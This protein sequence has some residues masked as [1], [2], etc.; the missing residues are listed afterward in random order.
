[1][2]GHARESH[3]TPVKGAASFVF[4][5]FF[6][7]AVPA[8]ADL[9]HDLLVR[10][11]ASW[12]AHQES[13]A[14][15]LCRRILSLKNTDENRHP[16]ACAHYLLSV[17]YADRLNK[18]DL[19]IAELGKALEMSLAESKPEPL[20]DV[21]CP[22]N[23]YY[24]RGM[25]KLG[26]QRVDDAIVDFKKS[27]EYDP[28]RALAYRALGLAYTTRGDWKR[29]L[30]NYSIAL[31]LLPRT[32]EFY[33]PCLVLRAE[34]YQKTGQLDR[35]VVDYTKLITMHGESTDGYTLRAACYAKLHKFDL[36]LKDYSTLIRLDPHDDN[37]Y[38]GRGDIFME[39]GKA[40]SAVNEYTR[41]IKLDPSPANYTARARAYEKLGRHDLAAQDRKKADESS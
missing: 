13:Q 11:W 16:L 30:E 1:M 9:S 3:L 38:R 26:A 22:A 25:Y 32:H 14:V 8:I 35:A 23:L 27:V 18:H 4:G 41:A 6:L 10:A 21:T 20:S 19:A 17:W 37:A 34:L 33:E 2:P 40:S 24:L 7:V 36:A 29:A 15:A 39:K 28:K 5:L 31:T 12:G